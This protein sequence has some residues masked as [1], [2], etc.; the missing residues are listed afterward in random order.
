MDS[1]KTAP[2][3]LG[4]GDDA[5]LLLHGFTGSPWD[6]RPLGEALAERG[7]YVKAPRLPGHGTTPDALLHVGKEDWQ[8]AA[9]QAL[10]GLRNFRQ[11]F[12][13][14]FSMGSLLALHLATRYP[15][16]VHALALLAPA[17]RLRD[18]WLRLLRPVRHLGLLEL[19]KPWV[20]KVGVDLQDSQARAQAPVLPAFPS[21]RLQSLWDLQ[22]EAL[23]TLP[24]VRCPTLVAVARQDHVV[25]F[26]VGPAAVRAL[27]SAPLVRF[28]CLEQGFHIMPRDT[29]GLLLATELTNFFDRQRR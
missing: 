27:T 23:L 28:I 17:L 4:H 14:G 15:E 24:R 10:S 21:A 7:F 18:R 8:E 6:L 20:R 11:T 9:E 2:F 16:R 12:V 13:T 26:E 3:E 29:D 25:P 5:C 22:E 19:F 1:D